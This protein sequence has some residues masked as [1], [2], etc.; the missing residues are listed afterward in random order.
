VGDQQVGEPA[1]VAQPPDQG[2]DPGL[3]GDVECAGRLVQDQQPGRDGE[4]P[5]DRD[6]LALPAGQPMR[7]PGRQG[8]VQL[9][10]KFR[11]N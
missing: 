9:I 2:E 11:R 5:G 8:R 1:L 3:R 6:P 10:R 4:R 7:V